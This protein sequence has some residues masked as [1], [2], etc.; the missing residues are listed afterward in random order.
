VAA[1]FS[2]L[3]EFQEILNCANYFL[4]QVEVNNLLRAKYGLP[5]GI[6]V[7]WSRGIS[8]HIELG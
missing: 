3:E 7:L 8:G 2:G 5:C 1:M 6:K 4:T